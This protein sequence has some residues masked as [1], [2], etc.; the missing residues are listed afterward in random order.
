MRK[1]VRG[2]WRLLTAPF[3]RTYHFF[4]DPAPD[5]PLV[6][7]LQKASDPG[8]FWQAI[9][10]HL[11]S[12]RGR[13]LR[14]LLALIAT[15]S[16][17]FIFNT[18]L[19]EF[20]AVPVGG[21]QTLIAIEVTEQIGVYMRVA[22]LAGVTLALPYIVLQ[23]WVF[24]ATGFRPLTRVLGLLAIPLATL[25]FLG[26]MAFAYYVMLP[27][28]LP[29]LAQILV[30]E[31]QWTAQSYFSFVINLL[32]WIGVSAEFPLVIAGLARI[33]LVTPRTLLKQWRLAV[34]LIAIFAAVITPTVDPINMGLLMLPLILLYLLSIGLSL[35]TYRRKPT[36]DDAG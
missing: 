18:Q 9:V 19:L 11:D 8:S 35:L 1:L 10:E 36:P 13:L 23:L 5:Q 3:R 14:A 20:L 25:L 34:V 6:E 29:L 22:L 17:S 16:F 30:V 28:A 15:V 33:G 31:T 26:G 2:L 27:V 4:T 32:F 12:L 21:M 24:L 7:T